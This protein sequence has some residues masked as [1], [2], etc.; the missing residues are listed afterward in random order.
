M[1]F[2][3]PEVPLANG[4]SETLEKHGINVIGCD[5]YAAQLE[6]S[7][8]FTKELCDKAGIKTAA[9]QVFTDKDKAIAYLH[10]T[11]KFPIVIKADGLAA[12][13]GVI[14]SDTKDQAI[15]AVDEIFAGKFGDMKKIVIEEFLKGIEASFFAISDGRTFKILSNAGDHKRIGEGD[16]GLNTG[17]MGTYSPTP[18]VTK[19]VEDKVINNILHPTFELLKK[20]GHPYKGIIF[21]GL[22]I[23]DEEEVYLIEYNIRFGDPEAQSILVRLET[24]FLAI[25]Q[26]VLEEKLAEIEIKFSDDKAITV[27]LAANGYP[28][29]YQKGTIISNLDEVSKLPNI[30]IFHAGTKL[31]NEV[32]VAN[33]GRVL[34]I[35]AVGKNFD[36]AYREVYKAVDMVNWQDKYYR[37]DIAKKILVNS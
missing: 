31:E 4:I 29:S 23:T 37:K 12:G 35:T 36:D 33:G 14:I 10:S 19:Q 13:K 26:A 27:V 5:S 16:T 7:K 21:A 8:S 6:S 18:Y 25:C 17:G 24:D 30:K 28:E 20:E 9:Y 22:M 34:N 2:R 32:L 15:T 11:K 3:S 1:L